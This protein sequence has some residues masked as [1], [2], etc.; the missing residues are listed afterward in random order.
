MAFSVRPP[1][2]AAGYLAAGVL[3]YFVVVYL[4]LSDRTY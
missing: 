3:G 4:V 1:A 2:L